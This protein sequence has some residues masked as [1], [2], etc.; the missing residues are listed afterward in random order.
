MNKFD[1]M[2]KDFFSIH[3]TILK[4]YEHLQLSD[5]PDDYTM[6]YKLW[7]L[8]SIIGNLAL[9]DH[10]AHDLLSKRSNEL[11]YESQRNK[12]LVELIQSMQAQ[13]D[14]TED[15]EQH[16]DRELRDLVHSEEKCKNLTSA[17]KRCYDKYKYWREQQ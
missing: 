11:R 2:F 1:E 13:G 9:T 3:K 17:C 6:E 15:M 12:E 14:F 16:I 10:K 7:Y 4:R 5:N 8:R